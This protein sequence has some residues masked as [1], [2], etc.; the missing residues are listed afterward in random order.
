MTTQNSL[1]LLKT[2]VMVRLNWMVVGEEN[3]KKNGEERGRETDLIRVILFCTQK[4]TVSVCRG[5][6]TSSERS[7]LGQTARKRA[8]LRGHGPGQDAW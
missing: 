5:K 6:K 4:T 8:K 2:L 1:T 7:R 3:K